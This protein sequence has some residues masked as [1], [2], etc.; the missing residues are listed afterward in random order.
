MGLPGQVGLVTGGSRGIGRSIA[1]ALAEAGIQ[2]ALTYN[3]DQKSAEEAV[4]A[5]VARGGR[6]IAIELTI[7]DGVAIRQAIAQVN[8]K[9]GPIDILINNAAIAQEKPFESITDED[10]DRMFAVNLRG[11]FACCQGVLP[12]MREQGYGRIINL[13]SI[14]GQWGGWRQVHYAAAK[15]GVISLTRSLARLYAEYGITVN[16]V[17]PGLVNTEMAA[18]EIESEEGRQK[19]SNIPMKRIGTL[20][21]IASVAVFLIS[22]GAGYITG[23]TINVNGGMY[24]G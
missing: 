10:W 15:A 8:S 4:E 7:E 2:V 5:I 3:T 17:S 23:Q 12:S 9:L 20:Q 1:M 18:S 24:F 14:G 16:A 19:V 13:A 6:A 21:E 11:V 22:K